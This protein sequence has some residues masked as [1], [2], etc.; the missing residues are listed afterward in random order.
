M[1]ITHLTF[2]I[3]TTGSHPAYCLYY[4][5]MRLNL[6]ATNIIT[7]KADYSVSCQGTATMK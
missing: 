2:R 5:H 1:K 7:Y 4:S 6:E 3:T